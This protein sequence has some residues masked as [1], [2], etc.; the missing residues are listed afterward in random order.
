MKTKYSSYNLN[1]LPEGCKYCVR[2][3]KLVLFISGICSRSCWYCSL[4]KKRKNKDIVWANERVCKSEKDF[5]YEVKDSNATSMGIT[6]GDPLLFLN[7]TLKYAKI[8]KKKFGKK[9]HI[10]IYL[11]TKLV[12]KDKIKKLSKY[13]DEIRFN[14]EYSIRKNE[15]A[16]KEDIEKIKIASLFYKKENIGIELPMIPNRKKDFLK[17]I[18]ELKENIGFVNLNEF[19]LSE[20]NLSIVTKKY[21]LNEGGYVISDSKQAGIWLLH[22]LKERKVKL[23]VHF[24]T[25]ELKNDHQFRNRLLRYNLLPFGYRTSEGMVKYLAIYC[26]N[27][28]EFDSLIKQFPKNKV[29]AD[30][31]KLRMIISEKTAHELIN[32]KENKNKISLVEEFPTHDRI[33]TEKQ[34][35]N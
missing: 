34:E 35:L 13:V 23:Q 6:G 20:S 8:A 17:L 27:K 26:K 30:H 9:F 32:S 3:E 18:L 24:C 33:E 19:E 21:K 14:P 11:P 16:L 12:T 15:E 1:G 22:E 31:K 10:H 25:A 2:G 5:I 29:Y 4:S 28:K 7:R